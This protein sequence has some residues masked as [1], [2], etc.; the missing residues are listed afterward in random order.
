MPSGTLAADTHV[1]DDRAG[2]A[3]SVDAD[4]DR[5]GDVVSVGRLAVLPT[6]QG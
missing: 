2:A 5:L 3:L 6:S 1:N 4:S